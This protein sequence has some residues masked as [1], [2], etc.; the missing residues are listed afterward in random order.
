[1]ELTY[2]KL[3]SKLHENNNLFMFIGHGTKNQF[4]YI[5]DLKSVL[6]TILEKI[7]K[8]SAVLYF[9]DSP[10]SKKPDIGYAFKLINNYRPDIDI[11]MIQISEAKN[12]GTPDFVKGVYWHNNYTQKCKWGGFDEK[13]KTPCSNTKVWLSIAKKISISAIFVLGGGQITLDEVKAVKKIKAT[14]HI[15]HTPQIIYVPIER[16]FKGDGKTRVSDSDTKSTRIGITY[17]YFKNT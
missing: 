10:D 6:K 15:Q 12:W 11:Y 14:T 9:G 3:I 5:N 2:N 4:R 1:M 16:R 17:D 13:T 8:N 7:P